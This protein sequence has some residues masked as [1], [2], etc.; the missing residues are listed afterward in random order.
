MVDLGRKNISRGKNK[1]LTDFSYLINE[2]KNDEV[3]DDTKMKGSDE[4][5]D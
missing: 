2:P 4:K 1:D 3:E 5:E